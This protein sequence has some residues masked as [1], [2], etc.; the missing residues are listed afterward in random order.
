MHS[1][2]QVSKR[3]KFGNREHLGRVRLSSTRIGR[4][5]EFR[6]LGTGRPSKIGNINT[7]QTLEGSLYLLPRLEA[8]AK[9]AEG[10]CQNLEVTIY[11]CHVAVILGSRGMQC[12][13]DREERINF[14][15]DKGKVLQ[16]RAGRVSN[17]APPVKIR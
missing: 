9:P 11:T 7:S 14:K 3:S 12:N 16:T 6:D 1:Y 8:N 5:H 4:L 15:A 17:S 13:L 2:I 10:R